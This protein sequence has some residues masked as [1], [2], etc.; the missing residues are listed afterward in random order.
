[1]P[2]NEQ[3]DA[4]D[5]AGLVTTKKSYAELPSNI[6]NNP[7][8][9]IGGKRDHSNKGNQMKAPKTSQDRSKMTHKVGKIMVVTS[10]SPSSKREKSGSKK[11]T[12]LTAAPT[13]INH[14]YTD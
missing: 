12:G 5:M 8:K 7:N 2:F 13:A 10:D 4:D 14:E 11:V 6:F 1:M 3:N 9:N